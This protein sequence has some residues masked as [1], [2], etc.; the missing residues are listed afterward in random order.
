MIDNVAKELIRIGN[1]LEAIESEY[2]IVCS[3]MWGIA[4]IEREALYFDLKRSNSKQLWGMVR[5]DNYGFI[6]IMPNK[7]RP[8]VRIHCVVRGIPVTLFRFQATGSRTFDGGFLSGHDAIQEATRL[9]P[10]FVKDKI[11][12]LRQYC[13]TERNSGEAQMELDNIEK[14]K[15]ELLQRIS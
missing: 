14:R 2:G 12:K 13:Q 10:R 3:N 6:G 15:K 8:E 7:W 4:C 11:E 5:E 9:A 1:N